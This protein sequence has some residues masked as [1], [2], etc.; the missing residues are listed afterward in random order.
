MAS[1]VTLDLGAADV[2][3]AGPMGESTPSGASV[4]RSAR[5]DKRATDRKSKVVAK[6]PTPTARGKRVRIRADLGAGG[7]LHVRHLSQLANMNDGTFT[8]R[9][10][11]KLQQG[12][13]V[14]PASA[15]V[16]LVGP[17][18][19][20]DGS[21]KKLVW[22]QLAEVG[23]W[24][25]HSSGAFEMTPATFSEIV[26]NFEARVLPIPFDYEHASEQDATQGSVP[27]SG[28]PAPGW[29]HRLDNRGV[30]GLWGLTEWLE[31]ARDQIKAGE[32]A[33]LSPAI[34]F[35]SR[36]PKSGVSTGAKLTSVALTNQPFLTGIGHLW[37]ARDYVVP[38]A[39]QALAL[40]ATHVTPLQLANKTVGMLPSSTD[41]GFEKPAHSVDEY[42][43][44]IK[45]AFGLHPLCL[46]AECMD[47]LDKLRDLCMSLGPD[48]V[49]EGVGLSSYTKPLRDLVGGAPGMTWGDVFDRV[50]A[51]IEAAIAE[52]E[53]NFHP[54]A[55]LATDRATESTTTPVVENTTAEA[56]PRQEDTN[57]A[58]EN[59]THAI[60]LK[61]AQDKAN[62]LQL[63]AA[64][65]EATNSKLELQLKDAQ[66]IA[67]RAE[68]A[69][70]VIATCKA[71]LQLK[72]GETVEA[73]VARIVEANA[74][75]LADKAKRDE[76]DLTMDVEVAFATY[77]DV[78]KL[79][80]AD[81]A[82]MVRLCK[83]DREAFNG[84]YPPVSPEKRHL[85][86]A[87]TPP[88]NREEEIKNAL[89]PELSFTGLT[90]Q[91]VATGKFSLI[92]AQAEAER[93]LSGQG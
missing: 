32:Y 52:H 31:T 72:D 50:E 3:T 74:K 65:L 57:M 78:K 6:A 76:D 49:H 80:D 83:A 41:D 54:E 7:S 10:L 70:K 40:S 35:G 93:Q 47:H 46:A 29:V 14:D 19:W 37:A 73:G 53:A 79:S 30:G 42:M 68:S 48:G 85:L 86:R 17:A 44:Q 15:G 59:K 61:D 26:R 71:A 45:A 38:P 8:L 36:D 55:A 75:L 33:F 77:K 92:E 2:H 9:D 12:D 4:T 67:A 51:L 64:N 90:R 84:M 81:K 43:P 66:A 20:K 62:E 21:A 22:I 23:A 69:E 1:V 13:E 82:H 60:A 28:A 63:K 18:T 11:R 34:R 88:V 56:M 5:R 27:R 16:S 39:N 58:D 89:K 91:L 25:G 87:I 24:K